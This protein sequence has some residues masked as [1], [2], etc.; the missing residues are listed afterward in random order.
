MDHSMHNFLYPLTVYRRPVE[1]AQLVFKA[2]LQ[3]FAHQVSYISNLNTNGK[4]SSD[5]AF[6]HI[7]HLW[8]T[9]K[10]SQATLRLEHLRDQ[11]MQVGNVVNLRQ[12]FCPNANSLDCFSFGKVVSVMTTEIGMEVLVHLC[13]ADGVELYTDEFGYQAIYSFCLDDIQIPDLS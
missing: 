4:L 3:E 10:R 2:N 9:L 12:P 8:K 13:N 6:S 11:A 1:P 7:H 5:E